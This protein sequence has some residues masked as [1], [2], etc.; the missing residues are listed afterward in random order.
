MVLVK[1]NWDEDLSRDDDKIW[2]A[3]YGDEVTVEKEICGATDA[4]VKL[5]ALSNGTVQ[6]SGTAV[7]F[8]RDPPMKPN[9]FGQ[10]V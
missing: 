8:S 6:W 1:M 10:W 3:V 2:E 4:Y 5:I 7:N 9:D